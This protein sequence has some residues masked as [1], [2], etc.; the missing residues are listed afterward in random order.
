M[1]LLTEPLEPQGTPQQGSFQLGTLDGS[2]CRLHMA[3]FALH[4]PSVGL[5]RLL[6]TW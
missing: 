2:L 3:P 5:I 1:S 6:P 4:E